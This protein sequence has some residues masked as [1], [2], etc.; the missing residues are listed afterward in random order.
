MELTHLSVKELVTQ[1]KELVTQQKAQADDIHAMALAQS[2]INNKLPDVIVGIDITP[3]QASES[4]DSSGFLKLMD[5]L[6]LSI[7]VASSNVYSL[8]NTSADQQFGWNW[9]NRAEEDAYEP[10][11]DYLSSLGKCCV[12]VN[13]GNFCNDRNLFSQHVWSIRKRNADGNSQPVL[14][15]GRVRGCVDIVVLNVPIHN[16]GYITRNIVKY[17]FEIK[18]HGVLSQK[19]KSCINEVCVQ[20]IGLC[21]YNINNTPCI[22]L[23]DLTQLHYVVYLSMT[24]DLPLLKYE[25]I[26]Q[27]CDRL[28]SAIHLAEERAHIFC[29]YNFG[30]APTPPNTVYEDASGVGVDSDDDQFPNAEGEE[31]INVDNHG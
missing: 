14:H 22:I 26:V 7:P 10:L 6:D 18:T 15:V 9:R 4:K 25:I 23:T 12:D 16:G 27:R 21:G 2:L 19:F 29:S 20:I 28:L 17:G 11:C 31:S 1:Q 8:A 24:S 3:S 30:R 13:K 5:L